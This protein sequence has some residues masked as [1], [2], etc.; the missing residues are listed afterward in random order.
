[1]TDAHEALR[2]MRVQNPELPDELGLFLISKST[3]T[4]E[5]GLRWSFD[6][7]HKTF[8]PRPFEARQ[9]EAILESI[10]TPTLVVA[11]AQGFRLADEQGRVGK[12]RNRQFVEIADVGHMIH[13]F[14]PRALASSLTSFFAAHG[15]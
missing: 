13:W 4:V 3:R 9:F 14:E 5:G 7:L 8:S 2:R 10:E 11:G 1:M 6:P 12:I 15:A